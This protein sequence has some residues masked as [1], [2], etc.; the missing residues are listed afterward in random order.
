[1]LF[2]R[3]G[4]VKICSK[5]T[6]EHPCQSVISRGSFWMILFI[7]LLCDKVPFTCNTGYNTKYIIH[8]LKFTNS[9]NIN[10]IYDLLE[11]PNQQETADSVTFTEEILNGK[12]HLLCSALIQKSFGSLTIGDQRFLLQ[13]SLLKISGNFLVTRSS[14]KVAGFHLWFFFNKDFLVLLH[15]AIT[16]K[17]STPFTLFASFI[18]P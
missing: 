16:R 15:A 7:L 10:N 17:S 13:F 2:L 9:L 8:H 14:I 5:F 3:K 6:G 18:S 12:L 1:M 4:A 11:N